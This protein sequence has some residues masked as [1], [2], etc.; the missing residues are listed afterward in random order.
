MY[1]QSTI[2]FLPLCPSSPTCHIISHPNQIEAVAYAYEIYEYSLKSEKKKK[3]KKKKKKSLSK[4]PAPMAVSSHMKM[5]TV[6]LPPIFQLTSGFLGRGIIRDVSA[7][8][9]NAHLNC[10]ENVQILYVLRGGNRRVV[11]SC[12]ARKKKKK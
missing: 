8:N 4:L 5:A 11:I 7:E 3:R 10:G 12:V 1:V 6:E 2:R 9:S